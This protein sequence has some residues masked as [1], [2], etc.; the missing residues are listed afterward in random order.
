V[1]QL[2]Q[3]SSKILT[4]FSKSSNS[5]VN[6]QAHLCPQN[7]FK[8]GEAFV[9]IS[10]TLKYSGHLNDATACCFSLSILKTAEGL[11]YFSVIFPATIQMIPS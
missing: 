10:I 4:T 5:I 9:I 3:C 11:L 7:L 8:Y 6:P 1:I 2:L